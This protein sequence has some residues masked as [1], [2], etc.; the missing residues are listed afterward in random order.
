MLTLLLW[1]ALAVV[2][3]PLAILA[4]VLYQVIWLLA[5]PFRIVGISVAAALDLVRAAVTFP[6]RLLGSGRR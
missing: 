1:I 5:I 4:L 2:S 6:A 3:L